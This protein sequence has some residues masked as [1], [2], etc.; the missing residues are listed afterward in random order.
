MENRTIQLQGRVFLRFDIK[1]VTGLHIGG[2]DTGIEIGGVDKTVIRDPV[3]NQP[4]IPGSSL[5]GKMRSLTEK[6]EGAVQN[7]QIGQGFIHSCQEERLYRDCDICQVYGVPGERD[8]ATPTRL[9]VRD[10]HLTEESEKKLASVRTDL[11][12]TEVKTE[13]SIDRV[14]SAANPRQMERVPA[15]VTFGR[16]EMVYSVYSGDGIDPERDIAR[17][18]TVVRGLQLL[19]DDYLGGLGS[20]GSG[21][22]RLLKIEVGVKSRSDYGP[23]PK[24]IAESGSVAELA[25]AQE[26]VLAGIRAALLE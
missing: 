21:K 15:G 26:Q 16:A 1:T 23:Q 13:V 2:S 17:F 12:Y 14:T 18:A 8:F 7:Q 19:E 9:I 25:A 6:Y 11:P 22:V 24:V 3:T 5:R 4:Y 20:R 10:V